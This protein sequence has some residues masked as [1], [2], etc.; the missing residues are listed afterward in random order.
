M[1]QDIANR[2]NLRQNKPAA[3]RFRSIGITRT[4]MSPGNQIAQY[5]GAS[6]NASRADQSTIPGLNEPFP[7]SQSFAP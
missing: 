2:L 7:G 5:G 4:A 6:I 3:R 1:I